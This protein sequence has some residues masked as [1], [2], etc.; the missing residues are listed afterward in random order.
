MLDGLVHP[1]LA[2]DRGAETESA[3]QRRAAVSGPAEQRPTMVRAVGGPLKLA[4]SRISFFRN[5]APAPD[6]P[7]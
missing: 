7:E 5:G 2:A 4:L 1:A 3:T 6:V